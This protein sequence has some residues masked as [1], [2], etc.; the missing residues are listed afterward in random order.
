MASKKD[1]KAVKKT[2]TKKVSKKETKKT[3]K[4]DTKAKFESTMKLVPI[5]SEKS[6]AMA[7]ESN[8]YS[9]YAPLKVNKIEMKREIEQK[10]NVKVINVSSI[11]RPGKAKADWK[12]GK[13]FRKS[14]K[15]KFIVQLKDGD[16]IDEF[17]N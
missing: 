16:K 1:T 15:K 17:F 13:T 7:N 2:E 5:I 12:F 4:K 9:F 14:D 3:S 10:Y 6:F 8:K 11:T